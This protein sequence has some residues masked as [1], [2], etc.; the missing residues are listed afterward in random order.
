MK[1]TMRLSFTFQSGKRARQKGVQKE[2]GG[3]KA[4]FKD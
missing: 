1:T 4:L 3:G 2:G